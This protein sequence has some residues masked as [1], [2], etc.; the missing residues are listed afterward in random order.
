MS[1]RKESSEKQAG[2]GNVLTLPPRSK[3]DLHDG[4]AIRREL[5]TLYRDARTGKVSTQDATRLAY[6]LD[7]LRRAYETGVLQDRLEQLEKTIDHKKN[8]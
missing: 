1:S 6:I 5:G 7:L 2:G 3:I 8:E 4:H